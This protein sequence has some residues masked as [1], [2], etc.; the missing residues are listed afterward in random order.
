MMKTIDNNDLINHIDLVYA[1]IK[2]EL[3]GP[4]WSSAVYYENQIG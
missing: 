2:I 4:K 1:K 3:S